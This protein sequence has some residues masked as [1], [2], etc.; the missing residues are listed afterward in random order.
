MG[1]NFKK[2]KFVENSRGHRE[3][4]SKSRDSSM[5]LNFIF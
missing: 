3:E 5:F 2:D 4:K 1:Y